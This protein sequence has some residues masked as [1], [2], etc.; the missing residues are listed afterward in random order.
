MMQTPKLKY[1]TPTY[2]IILFISNY[3]KMFCHLAQLKSVSANSHQGAIIVI[4]VFIIDNKKTCISHF[5][6][7]RI[8]SRKLVFVNEMREH[9]IQGY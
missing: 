5:L 3:T 1:N 2:V 6:T 8:R 7:S 4:V 9:C